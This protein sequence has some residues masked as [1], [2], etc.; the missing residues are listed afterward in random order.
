M[1]A[2]PPDGSLSIERAIHGQCDTNREPSRACIHGAIVVS[3]GDCMDVICLD[4]E[5]KN[6]EACFRC[7]PDG[8]QDRTEDAGTSERG[9]SSTRSQREVDGVPRPVLASLTM[10]D[11]RPATGDGRPARTVTCAAATG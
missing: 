8:L 9:K 6:P 7:S 11:G 4:R 2:I 5:G 10:W 1:V 3:L